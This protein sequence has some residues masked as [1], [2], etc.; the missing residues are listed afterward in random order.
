MTV[1][2]GHLSIL[3][4][5]YKSQLTLRSRTDLSIAVTSNIRVFLQETCIHSTLDNVL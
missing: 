1:R 4:I 5:I 2:L 3:A